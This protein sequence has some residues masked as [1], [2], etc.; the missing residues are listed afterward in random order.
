MSGI[1][2]KSIKEKKYKGSLYDLCFKN[3]HYFYSVS[4]IDNDFVT[5]SKSAILVHNSMPDIELL[6]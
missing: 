6:S 2:I 5:N 1:K 4:N 3:E